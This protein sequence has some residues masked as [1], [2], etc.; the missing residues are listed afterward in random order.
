MDREDHH[1]YCD[2]ESYDCHGECCGPDNC[3]CTPD[4]PY[5]APDTD[6]HPDDA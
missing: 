1:C 6:S 3:S 2:C 5:G 4:D